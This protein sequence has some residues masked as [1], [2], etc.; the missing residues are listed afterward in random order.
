MRLKLSRDLNGNK[1][2]KVSFSDGTRGFSVQTN[3]NLPRTHR[4]SKHDFNNSTAQNELHGYIK[5]YGTNNQKA[6]LGW[7]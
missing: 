6:L 1:T 2:L 5:E 7:Y 3:G 4:M